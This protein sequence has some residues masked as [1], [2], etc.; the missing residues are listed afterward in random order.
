MS[1]FHPTKFSKRTTTKLSRRER[2][3]PPSVV[4]TDKSFG[5]LL[6]DFKNTPKTTDAQLKKPVDLDETLRAIEAAKRRY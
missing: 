1:G 4:R 5:R 2:F 3:S 6:R